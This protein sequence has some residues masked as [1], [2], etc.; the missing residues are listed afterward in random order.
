[1]IYAT[2]GVYL[3]GRIAVDVAKF[4]ANGPV[5]AELTADQL[6]KKACNIAAALC[7]EFQTRDWVFDIPVPPV[8]GSGDGTMGESDGKK[9]S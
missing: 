7:D 9:G 5:A 3:P 4:M 6:V 1:M 8:E 2:K